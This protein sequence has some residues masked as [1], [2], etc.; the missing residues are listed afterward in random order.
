MTQNLFFKLRKEVLICI[1][2]ELLDNTYLCIQQASQMQPI[3]DG[4]EGLPSTQ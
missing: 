3:L 4:N 2:K 1:Y